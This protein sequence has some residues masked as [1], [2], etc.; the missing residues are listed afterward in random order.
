MCIWTDEWNEV[1]PRAFSKWRG[2][3]VPPSSLGSM[4]THAQTQGNNDDDDDDASAVR[5]SCTIKKDKSHSL[6]GFL[7]HD[8]HLLLKLF[9]KSVTSVSDFD[10]AL[11]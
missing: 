2:E 9:H 6:F 11:F 1:G 10:V 3:N 4:Q 8:M 7:F 5:P